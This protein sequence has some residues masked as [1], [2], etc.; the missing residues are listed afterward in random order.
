MVSST[1]L[2]KEKAAKSAIYGGAV[3]VS[4]IIMATLA[5]AHFTLG[6]ITPY[7]IIEIQKTNPAMVEES[8]WGTSLCIAFP[9]VAPVTSIYKKDLLGII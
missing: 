8:V 9:V 2:L 3:A 4:A 7:T 6:S 1:S 5:A